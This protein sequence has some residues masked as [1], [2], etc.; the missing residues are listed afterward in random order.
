[1]KTLIEQRLQEALE[2]A[3]RQLDSKNEVD[4]TTM[5][6]VEAWNSLLQAKHD[7]QREKKAKIVK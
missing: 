3:R 1:M 7:A 5:D 4:V 2:K 6:V